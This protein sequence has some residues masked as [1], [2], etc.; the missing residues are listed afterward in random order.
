[1]PSIGHNSG[2]GTSMFAIVFDLDT[3]SLKDV[4]GGPSWNN[5]YTDFRNFLRKRGFEWQ[6]GST[7]FGDETVNEV[8]C[9]LTIQDL[10]DAFD[11]FA[12]VV[13][14]IRMLRIESNNDLMPAVERAAR[15]KSG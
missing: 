1:M 11:W 4:Y 5:A 12:P 7:Y 14:D 13:R 10:T 3:N 9:V 2:K 8:S 15:R 6:Q